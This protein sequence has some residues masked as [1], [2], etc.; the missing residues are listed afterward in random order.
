MRTASR[1]T[2]L[3]VGAGL[4]A[5]LVLGI[6][7]RGDAIEIEKEDGATGFLPNAFVQIDPQGIVTITAPRPDMG[8]GVRTSLAMLVAEEL[9]AEW[10]KVQV[11][12]APGDRQ[13]YGGQTVGGSGSVRGSWGPLRLAGATA[14]AMLR[15]AAASKWGVSPDT[16]TIDKGRIS[17]GSKSGS[18]ADFVG[19]A[20][21][22]PVPDRSSITLKTKDL[23]TLI[24]KPVRR[25]DNEAVVTGKAVFGLDVRLPGMKTAM[26][27][28]PPAFGGKV[29]SFNA[30]AAKA[31]EGVR[32]VYEGPTGVVVI[33]DDTWRAHKGIE[34]LDTK[35]DAGPNAEFNSAEMTRRFKEAVKPFPDLPSGLK[36]VEATYEQPFLAH[37]P[38]EPMNCTVHITNDKCEIWAPTQIPDSVRD[39]AARATGLD[40]S[41]VTVHVT[42]LGGGFGRRLSADFISEAIGIAQRAKT[43]IQLVWTR[44][45]DTKHDNYRPANYHAVRGGVDA[46]G[47][48][49]AMLWQSFEAGRGRGRG[50][51]WTS[52]RLPYSMSTVSVLQEGVASP[53]PTGAWRSVEHTYTIFVQECFF[54]ELCHAGGQDPVKA[55][56]ALMTNDR[57]KRT[58]EMCAEKAGWGK[59]MPKGWGRGVAC[60]SGYGSNITQI[61]DVEIKDGEIKVRRVV[62]V[63]DC[64]LAVNPLG[65]EAQI[66]GATMDAVST[67]IGV[68]IAIQNGA[69]RQQNFGDIGWGRIGDAPHVEVHIIADGD[70]PGG[71]GEVGYPAAVPAILNAVFA[72]TGQRIRR[73]PAGDELE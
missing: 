11:V 39:L 13:T 41:K 2:V 56:L 49:A 18:F 60:F 36:V 61:A 65:I 62:A 46:T 44:I 35:F 37:N 33:A 5:G 34:A 55:R 28:R 70:S 7:V 4:G 14:A 68:K 1:R 17:S 48:P 19:E 57:L 27:A 32:D 16:V 30:E 43:P 20:A 53:V 58:L 40:A 21:R 25:V 6:R 23:F 52:L 71:M 22:L 10:E 38:M 31:I 45:D 59:A 69:V 8:Q 66:Q 54:D 9:G 24:G 26:I 12:Q 42:L 67:A 64:G 73:L 29:A 47:M 15:A 63:V 3:K 51:G 72:A 50:G